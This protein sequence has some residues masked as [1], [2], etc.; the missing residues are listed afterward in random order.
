MNKMSNKYE[1]RLSQVLEIENT[2]LRERLTALKNEIKELQSELQ[3]TKNQLLT[4]IK[5]KQNGK[6]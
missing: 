1:I 6:S 3:N 5:T 2:E 4:L